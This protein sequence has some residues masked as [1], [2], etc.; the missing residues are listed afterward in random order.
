MLDPAILARPIQGRD[1]D[2]AQRLA[3]GLSAVG[4]L[5]DAAGDLHG[6][7]PDRLA[8]LIALL[9]EPLQA[10]LEELAQR[11]DGGAEG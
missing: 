1:L 4:D 8:T 7:R 11:A 6:V 9:T 2:R 3:Q 10:E 5:V